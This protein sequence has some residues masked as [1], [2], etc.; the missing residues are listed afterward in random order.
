MESTST[1]GYQEEKKHSDD[2]LRI[3]HVDSP[4]IICLGDAI[5]ERIVGFDK[6]AYQLVEVKSALAL[7]F[8]MKTWGELN[9]KFPEALLI[10]SAFA[11]KLLS[12]NIVEI[13]NKSEFKY[14]PLMMFAEKKDEYVTQIVKSMEADDYFYNNISFDFLISRISLSKRLRSI[15]FTWQDTQ[16]NDDKT[17]RM[18][19][20]KRSFDIVFSAFALLMLSP[21]LI[22]VAIAIKLES[23]GPI[24]YI[25][26]RAGSDYQIFDFYKFRS[27]SQDADTQLEKLKATRNQY[28][29]GNQFVKIQNDPRITRLGH[30]LRSTSLDELPQLLNVLKGDMSI[31]GNRPLPLY[32][33]KLLTTDDNA[34]RFLGPA[35]ITGLWQALKRGKGEMS[36]EERIA[37]DRIYV[38]KNSVF[39]D[40]KIIL[41]TIPA[42]FQQEKV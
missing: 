22:L 2:Q 17:Y 36:S 30:I 23:K 38:R 42:L 37:L 24:F 32:E 41:M 11:S 6:E 15:G 35:G 29:D 26:K 9:S 12:E 16:L 39:F 27:M 20:F 40:I 3:D 28:K 13:R 33:A 10:D 25:S 19:M 4:I 18:Y 14:I 21:I 7:I 5:P 8:L 31:V 34:E 1:V